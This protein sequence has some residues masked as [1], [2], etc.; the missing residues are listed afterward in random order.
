MDRLKDKIA[1]VSGGGRGL[2]RAYALELAREG[3]A[4]VIAELDPATANGTAQEI[5]ALGGRALAVATDV[6]KRDQVN[7]AVAA[8]EQ[9]FGTVDILVNN[10]Q[11]QRMQVTFEDTSDDDMDVVIGS[12]VL[13]TFYFMQA[14]FPLLK[15][16]GGKVINVASAAG[17]S[18]TAG[19][20]SYA[21]A[22]EGIRALTKVAAHE[23][24]AH[25][26]NVNVICPAATT[27]S[28][29]EWTR[30]TPPLAKEMIDSI[31]LGRLGDPQKDVARAVVFLASSDSDFVT[32][33]TMMV[34]G[35]QTILH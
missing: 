33:L 9:A 20:T 17:L 7:A 19:W 12:G 5:E 31:P 13:G 26:I 14:C 27:P 32:G 6:M 34:D 11:I 8:A 30:T 2:G 18:G 10:A 16:S 24:G 23:W 4:I 1:I 28:F 3:A 25:Q 29:E 35:G 21:V 15:K 22:K